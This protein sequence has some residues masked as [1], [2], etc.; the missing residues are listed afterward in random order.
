MERRAAHPLLDPRVLARRD[1]ASVLAATSIGQ[2]ISLTG[3]STAFYRDSGYR[4]QLFTDGRLHR[5]GAGDL[6]TPAENPPIVADPV[7]SG[8]AREKLITR[9]IRSP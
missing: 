6:G 1:V 5:G 8:H 7:R 9:R 4:P 2:G 3:G